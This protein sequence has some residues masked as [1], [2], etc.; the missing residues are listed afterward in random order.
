VA[1]PLLSGGAIKC[2]WVAYIAGNA[3]YALG[4]KPVRVF[5]IL[6]W[7]KPYPAQKWVA[8][9]ILLRRKFQH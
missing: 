5:P 2:C 7:A 3:T 8:S 6:R 9:P 1:P 4:A